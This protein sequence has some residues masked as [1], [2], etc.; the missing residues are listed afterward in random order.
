MF[1]PTDYNTQNLLLV[2]IIWLVVVATGIAS[3]L[4]RSLD[5]TTKKFWMIMIVFLP[6]IGLL[7]YLPFSIEDP[8]ALRD[9][10][11]RVIRGRT[12]KQK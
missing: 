10:F 2:A 12:L 7:A 4:R 3:V 6:P 5:W 8:K 9:W 11:V 1:I